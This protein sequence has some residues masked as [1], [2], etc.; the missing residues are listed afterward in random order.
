MVNLTQLRILRTSV[1]EWNQWR[2]KNPTERPD[3]RGANLAGAQLFRAN[4][5]DAD[6]SD[7]D[8]R[9][10]KVADA[11]LTRA[12]LSGAKLAGAHLSGVDLRGADMTG[13]FLTGAFLRRA[14]LR[15]ADLTRARLVEA[16]MRGAFVA[17]ARLTEAN[18]TRADL[19]GATWDDLTVWPEG[20]EPPHQ[21]T[22]PPEELQPETAESG[23]SVAE[24]YEP[25]RVES[26]DPDQAAD[27]GRSLERL[28]GEVR[29]MVHDDVF[30]DEDTSVV[31][32]VLG[33]IERELFHSPVE[34][35]GTVL[36]AYSASLLRRIGPYLPED[37][38]NDNDPEPGWDDAAVHQMFDEASRLGEGTP[39]SDGEH[40]ANV[41]EAAA[42]AIPDPAS[43]EH[44]EPVKRQRRIDK[45]TEIVGWAGTGAAGG[46]QVLPPLITGLSPIWGAVVGAIF[47]LL[48]NV[49]TARKGDSED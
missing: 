1:T 3:L 47:G 26:L 8:L 41:V 49:Y 4:L 14:D 9:G 35:D 24:V 28:L 18:L 25:V 23:R 20:F 11:D 29:N 12:E 37:V 21:E 17:E 40:A 6:L 46:S 10:A 39:D 31:E 30:S 48:T 7:A 33:S 22:D 19:S 43:E 13:A 42:A 2:T 27:F 45:V 15:G 36:A 32:H 5:S 38:S 44:D 16:D 34:P